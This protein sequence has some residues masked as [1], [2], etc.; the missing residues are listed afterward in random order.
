MIASLQK[1]SLQF[2]QQIIFFVAERLTRASLH[3]DPGTRS[4]L[5]KLEGK[6]IS[7]H[8][9][10]SMPMYRDGVKVYIYPT[11]K[12]IEL[13]A[14]STTPADTSIALST[15][16]LLNLLRKSSTPNTIAIEGDSELLAAVLE[17]VNA[18]NIDWENAISPVTGDMIAHQMGKNMRATEKWLSQSIKEAKRLADEYMTEELPIA[19]ESKTFKSV[20]GGA[21]KMK[22]AGDAVLEKITTAAA[23]SPFF[24][25]RK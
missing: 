21:G 7:I 14:D 6:L 16:D 10:D 17:I 11:S 18:F 9:T 2:V 5:Q 13:S 8:I 4:R 12:G 22:E 1:N 25:P 20:F 3:L 24:K 15:K 23:Q 19:K